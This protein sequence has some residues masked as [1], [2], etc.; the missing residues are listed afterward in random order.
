ME[1]LDVSARPGLADRVVRDLLSA[2]ED[3]SYPAG[4]RLPPET[5]LAEAAGVSRLTLREAVRVLRDKGVLR[6]EQGRGTFVNDSALWSAL[7]PEL[8]ASRAM[9]DGD[10]AVTAWQITET[11]SLVE[12]GVAGLAAERRSAADVEALRCEL[13]RMRGALHKDD[14]TDFS[15]A[16]IAFHDA[17]MRAAG[18]PFLAALMEPVKALVTQVRTHTSLALDMRVT[19]IAA[20]TAIM[21]AVVAGDADSARRTM[22]EHMVQTHRVIDRLVAS[23][24]LPLRP[25]AEPPQ[26]EERRIS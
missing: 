26:D 25:A 16:D 1:G 2:I 8:L 14:V 10:P 3:G 20:H 17:V 19:A 21:E 24:A 13:D 5:V 6:V 15:E 12:A 9:L 11:R 4:S 22:S 18:N 7:D 23:G